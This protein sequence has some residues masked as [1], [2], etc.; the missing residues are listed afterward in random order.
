MTRNLDEFITDNK[1]GLSSGTDVSIKWCDVEEKATWDMLEKEGK[2][3][4]IIAHYLFGFLKDTEL[5]IERV[6]EVLA[7]DGMFSC[8]GAE[9]SL[10]DEFWKQIFKDMKLSVDFI[11]EKQKEAQEKR[12][13]FK[14]LLEKYFKSAESVVLSNNM[15]YDNSSELYERLC[16]RYPEK[17]KYMS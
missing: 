9:V 5:L 15:R 3:D 4:C 10:E 16:E 6:A 11:S 7:E 2:Y 13:E 8:N 12:E 1:A 14:A 17:K